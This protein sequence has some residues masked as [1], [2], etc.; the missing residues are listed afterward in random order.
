LPLRSPV[1]EVAD[2]TSSIGQRGEGQE[3]QLAGTGQPPRRL[4]SAG[5]DDVQKRLP[6]LQGSLS[7][8]SEVEEILIAV[9]GLEE[10]I[11]V[12]AD[13]V[14]LDEL[15]VFL[16]MVAVSKDGLVVGA[17]AGEIL[18]DTDS[19]PCGLVGTDAE[20]LLA[21]VRGVEVDVREMRRIAPTK[22]RDE[23]A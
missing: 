18:R 10:V 14:G 6:R 19:G 4:D 15:E 7:N 17:D 5:L 1:Q 9:A 13:Q 8:Q 20:L 21:R 16:Q 2:P 11:V 22:V 23:P 12:V 3:P